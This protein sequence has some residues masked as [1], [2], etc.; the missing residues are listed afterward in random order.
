MKAGYKHTDVGVIPDDW[1]VATIGDFNPFVTSGSRGWA[2]Y[3]SNFGDPFIRITNMTRKRISLDQSSLRYVALPKDSAEGKRTKLQDDD[4]L[5]SITAD[6]GICSYVDEALAKPAYINQH[7]ALVRF[8]NDEIHPK[9]VN[10]YLAS[11]PVQRL[12][13]AGSDTGAKA[14]MNLEGIRSIKF[15]KPDATEQKA[16]AGALSDVDGLIAGLEALIAKKRS[17]KTATMQQL[18]TGKTRL[19]GFGV[20][21]GMKQTELGEIPA[22]WDVAPL[23]KHLTIRHGKSQKDVIS[24]DGE[25]PILATGGVIG[26][27]NRALY[28]K[29]SVLIGRKGTIDVPVYMDRP[30]WT[31]DTLFYSEISPA[32]DP[33]FLFYKFGFINW[34][35]YNEASGVPS[36]SSRTIEKINICSPSQ[37]SEQEA[38]SSVITDFD[39]DIAGVSGK[40]AKA[41]ALKQ[42]MMQE[43]LTGRT[44]LI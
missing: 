10:Y 39:N 11:D 2:E 43:L 7:I 13:V 23:G 42:G 18:L 5:I 21:V 4:I 14:G 41:K 28:D 22:D 30:F 27:A 40:L 36:L 16:I 31:V 26:R 37:K 19:P 8:E 44:R 17:L 15:A 38:I 25:F 1:D 3:Y 6:I 34:Y 33:K 29:P 9:Y 24:E 32:S 20:G 12:F 35:Q